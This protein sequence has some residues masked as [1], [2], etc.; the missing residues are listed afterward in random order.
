MIV[1]LGEAL[2][3]MIS[4]ETG[5][6]LEE[7]ERFLV[8]PGGAPA[9]VAVAIAKLAGKSAFIG[10]VGN[11]SF[12]RK[13]ISVMSGYGV[14]TEGMVRCD[15]AKTALAFVSL[16]S[17]GEREFSF[18]RDPGADML[19]QPEEVQNSLIDQAD[20]FHFGSISLSSEPSATATRYALMRARQAG[21]V[22]SYD[23]NWRPSLWS[24]EAEAKRT[25][26]SVMPCVDILK[27]NR[28][29]LSFLTERSDLHEAVEELHQRGAAVV[30]A[31]LD[32]EG[33]LYSC[34]GQERKFHGQVSGLAV[35]AVDTTGAG[36]TFV[37]AFLTL[38]QEKKLQISSLDEKS[39]HD[40][41]R[42]A[43]KAS[44][45]TV[46]R[47]GAMEAMPLRAEVTAGEAVD[48]GND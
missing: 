5:A 18:Y 13:L 8:R 42:F 9:N 29:E 31:T 36:D 27:V 33:C 7:T 44:A 35:S 40:M 22:I 11:D 4:L 3:D 17:D 25:M 21:K 14:N 1:C 16:R 12:G 15:K 23:P 6:S 26:L 43:V 41:V 2:I 39:M 28:E 38:W 20:I 47:H 48:E 46:T 34:R 10:K 45:V 30:L 32:R 37:G 19:L 24:D